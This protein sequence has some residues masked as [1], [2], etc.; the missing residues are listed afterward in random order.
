MFLLTGQIVKNSYILAGTYF[1]LDHT[2]IAFNT[3][4]GPQCKDWNIRYW[5]RQISALFCKL[6]AQILHSDC[7]KGL[8]AVKSLKQIKFAVAWGELKAKKLFSETMINKIFKT[9][10]GFHV[11]QCSMGKVQ[12]AFFR[13]FWLVLTKFSFWEE[14]WALGYNSMK[15]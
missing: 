11:K 14:D 5:A 4:F 9:N 1:V 10:S 12:F 3:Q 6:V 2:W 8:R 13:C 7:V 15:F